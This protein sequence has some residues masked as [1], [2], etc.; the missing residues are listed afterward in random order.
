MAEYKTFICDVCG[1]QEALHLKI[2]GTGYEDDPADGHRSRI[3]SYVD[4]CTVHTELFFPTM[5]SAFVITTTNRLALWEMVQGLIKK[6]KT[7]K[8]GY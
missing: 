6:T 8:K 7:S 5:V 2:P 4:L 1:A 3:D